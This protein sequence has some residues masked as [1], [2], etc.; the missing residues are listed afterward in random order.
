MALRLKTSAADFEPRFREL[1]AAKRESSPDVEAAVAEIVARVRQEGDAAL[2]DL[3]AL[4]DRVDLRASGI[5]V[6]TLSMGMSGDYDA[7]I[8][9]GATIIRIGTALFGQRN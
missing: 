5:D 8:Q 1:L 3:T 2:I 6:D 4:H 7:A 9:E